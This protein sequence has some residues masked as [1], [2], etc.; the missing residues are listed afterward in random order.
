MEF[1]GT[2]KF[3]VVAESVIQDD[4]VQPNWS[5]AFLAGAVPV[6]CL[7]AYARWVLLAVDSLITSRKCIGSYAMAGPGAMPPPHAEAPCIRPTHTRP[8]IMQY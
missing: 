1:V 3:V 5:Q 7:C 8:R 2:Y 4:W 6:G